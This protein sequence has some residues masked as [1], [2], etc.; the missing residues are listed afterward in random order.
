MTLIKQMSENDIQ[1][2]CDLKLGKGLS[3]TKAY[4]KGW[5]AKEE[6]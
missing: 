6:S 4:K 3:P 2:Y 1:H 5:G